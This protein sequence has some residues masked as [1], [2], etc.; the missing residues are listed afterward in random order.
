MPSVQLRNTF[1]GRI[2]LT[3]STLFVPDLKKKLTY[4]HNDKIHAFEV[5]YHNFYGPLFIEGWRVW[6]VSHCLET[7]TGWDL[8]SWSSASASMRP[9]IFPEQASLTAVS[10]SH[11]DLVHVSMLMHHKKSHLT[12]P[13]I[14]I[15]NMSDHKMFPK[16]KN[17]LKI[18]TLYSLSLHIYCL[19]VVDIILP[20]YSNMNW[21]T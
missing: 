3:W 4:H 19:V 7:G 18:W 2:S 20:S 6:I 12:I 14:L 17:I 9:F 8:P 15:W 5:N 21:Q 11:S 13:H 16:Q 10:K 1:H